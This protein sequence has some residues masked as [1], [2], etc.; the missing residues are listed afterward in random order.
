MGHPGKDG[1]EST[2][3]VAWEQIVG[4]SCVER[5]RIFFPNYFLFLDNEG[6][7]T[8]GKDEERRKGRRVYKEGTVK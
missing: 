3:A 4:R 6:V 7:N 8:A 5:M 1:E 2:G